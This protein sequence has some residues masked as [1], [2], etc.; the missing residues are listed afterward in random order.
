MSNILQRIHPFLLI[1]DMS[2]SQIASLLRSIK[3]TYTI[4]RSE[5]EGKKWRK[6]EVSAYACFYLPT[7]YQK[8]SFLMSQLPPHV[9]D[10][11]A[12]CEVIDF[13]TGPGTYL[14]AFADYFGAQRVS[15]L[16]GIDKDV[17]M[18][19][20]AKSL[21]H[22][23]YDSVNLELRSDAHLPK[24]SNPRLLIFGNSLNELSHNF[25]IDT[26]ESI[27]PNFTLFIEPGTPAVFESMIKVRSK[28]SKAGHN[29]F[30]PCPS[31]SHECPV[32]AKSNGDWCHQVW[33]GTHEVE[34]E[35]LGQ[36]A[37]IDRRVMPL[38]GHLYGRSG[39]KQDIQEVRFI[40][41]INESK[42]SFEWEV[43]QASE[44]LK[45]MTFEIPKKGLLKKEQKELKKLSV[46]EN[47]SY[48]LIKQ[49][50]DHRWRV[51]VSLT[52]KKTT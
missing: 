15:K 18:L 41:F 45:L 10:E 29:C 6:E 48:E 23:L 43:C 17:Q 31:L 20:Q 27:R 25:V 47:F 21:L 46:G 5:I 50:S 34:V 22:G 26:I 32:A 37:K 14:M 16:I 24:T 40:R 28:L 7:N 51:K 11:L 9:L 19:N 52:K 12:T 4:K 30:F 33:R 3:E 42:H 38:I 1:Q 49:V 44:S 39:S 35:K 13:G 8:F 2:D 36:M